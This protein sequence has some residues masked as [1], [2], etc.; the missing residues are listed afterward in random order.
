MGARGQREISE[1]QLSRWRLIEEFERCLERAAAVGKE[2]RTFRDPRRKLGQKDYL[3]LLLFG[4]FNPVVDSMRGLCAASRLRRV[5]EEICTAPVSL[6]SFSEAQAV[7]DPALLQRVFAELAAEQQCGNFQ[8][9]DKRLEPYRAQLLVIDGTLWRALPRMAWAL[10]RYQHGKESALRLHLKFNLWEEK[11][12]GVLVTSAR[13]CERAVLRTQLAAGEFY[14]GDRYYGEDYA[15]FSELEQARCFY[16]LRLRQ[17]ARFEVVEQWP[18]S[19]ADQAASVT[20]DGLVRLGAGQWRQEALVRLVRV[21]SERSELL[22]VSNKARE[23]LSAEL[24]ALIY[25]SRWRVELFFKWLKCILGC[26]HWLAESE[27]GVA[28]QVYCALI[29]ALLLLRRSGRRPGKRAM[30]M[31]RFYLLGYARLE[32]LSAALALEEKRI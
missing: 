25:R 21:Q 29:A 30:E 11:P 23:E 17:E 1:E 10:W 24:L 28:L 20:F 19:A 22:L 4:L 12:V 26:R 13:C 27:C 5:Q 14:V 31:I 9:T 16:L 15:L 7:V 3:S 6:G 18:L 8:N 2:P 32:E